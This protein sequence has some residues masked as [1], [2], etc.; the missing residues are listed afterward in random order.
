VP[1]FARGL[2]RAAK[3]FAIH[4][5]ARAHAVGDR[6]VDEVVEVAVVERRQPHQR[7]RAG[8]RRVLDQDAHAG[9]V[10]QRGAE[11][12]VDPAERRRV[13]D[14]AA[15]PVHHARHHQADPLA[16]LD[17]VRAQQPADAQRQ[18]GDQRRG[19]DG[20]HERFQR[21]LAPLEVAQHHRG[22]PEAYVHRHHET[23]VR[24]DVEHGGLAAAR[25]IGGLALA[26]GA[27]THELL[28]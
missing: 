10:G 22:V 18:L 8:D 13:Q 4:H 19:L 23:V 3:H 16:L 11:V 20:R 2:A 24:S 28:D 1:E 12:H 14:P 26:D 9:R 25:R 27:L 5:H 17:A 15:T 21:D 7:Q 6:Y